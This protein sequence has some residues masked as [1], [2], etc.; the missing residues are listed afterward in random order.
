MVIGI[1]GGIGSGKSTICRIFDIIGW[2]VYN[3]DLRARVLTDTNLLIK[4]QIANEFGNHLFEGGILNRRKLGEIVFKDAN[5]LKKLNEIIHPV[6]F[7]DFVIW[8]KNV[9]SSVVIKESAILFESGGYLLVDK[10]VTVSSPIFMRIKRIMHRDGLSKQ[11]ILDRMKNQLDDEE[12]MQRSDY[13]IIS[14][15]KHF[16]LS[17]VLNIIEDIKKI[18]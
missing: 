15:D 5:R 6:V 3:S 4:K 8:K 1:T 11:N 13:V 17:Q 14:D 12:R 10:I 9:N 7:E 2:P 18:I 16:L